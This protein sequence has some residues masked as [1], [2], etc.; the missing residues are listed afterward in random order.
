MPIGKLKV[1]N[2]TS[3]QHYKKR[4]PPWIKFHRTLLDDYEFYCLPVA[5]K[6]LAPQLWLLASESATGEIECDLIKIAH[7]LRIPTTELIEAL[8]PLIHHGFFL[9]DEDASNVLA[10]CYQR[11]TPETETETEKTTIEVLGIPRVALKPPGDGGV[12]EEYSA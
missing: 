11:A 5:S 4:N 8:G 10:L 12:L 1:K 9:P 3:F 7:R 2:W 6:A